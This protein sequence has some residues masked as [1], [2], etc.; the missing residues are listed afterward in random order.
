M[1]IFVKPLTSK[2]ITLDVEPSDSIEIVKAQI[3]NKEGIPLDQQ[4]LTFGDKQLDAGRTLSDYNIEKESTL[5]LV[6][7][8]GTF[9]TFR[10]NCVTRNGF[11][12]ILFIEERFTFILN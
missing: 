8:E 5:H 11:V 6:V 3:Q 9:L 1:H 12:C 10:Y 4:S 2:T 7:R